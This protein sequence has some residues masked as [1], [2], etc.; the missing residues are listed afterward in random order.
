MKKILFIKTPIPKL[1]DDALEPDMGL[2]CV[3]TYIQK[4]VNAEIRVIDLSVDTE[5]ELLN[6]CKEASILCFSTFTAT[7]NLTVELVKKIRSQIDDKKICIAGGHHAS[8]LPEEALKDFDYVVTGEGELIMTTLIKDLLSGKRPSKRIWDGKIIANLDEIDDINYDLVDINKYS[9]IVNG[10]KA[11]S[12]LT[13]RG[14]PYKC[15]FCNSTLSKDGRRVRFKSAEKVV[16]EILTLNEKYQINAFRIQDDIFSVN[17]QRLKKIAD[18]LEDFNF[19]FRCFARIDNMS[20]S[21]LFDFKRMGVK[22]ISFGI[23][24]GSQKILDAMNK[25]LRVEQ[26]KENIKKVIEKGFLVRI[27]LI[28]GYPGETYETIQETIELVKEC[29]PHE[30]S[31]YPLIP[32]PGTSLY[33]NPDKYGITYID[34]DFS[35]YY[36][37]YGNKES[38][39][40]YETK[41]LSIETIKQMRDY[42]VKQIDKVCIWAI[43]SEKNI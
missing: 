38:G 18:L 24:S 43:D 16:G 29:K 34:K 15:E 10:K 11:L 32:Y 13:S 9:R 5:E 8:A 1:Q 25:G 4:H 37:I 35:K 39:Y 7:Y 41:E 42:L 6:E 14:C 2:L 17:K 28:V 23:E 30:V 40:V 33:K 19:D 31:V 12:I 27:Y 36:Q 26:I 3:A 21:I 22:H 20:D